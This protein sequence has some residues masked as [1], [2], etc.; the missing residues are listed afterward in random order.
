M[1]GWDNVVEEIFPLPVVVTTFRVGERF[2]AQWDKRSQGPYHYLH[3]YRS[4]QYGR[5][6]THRVGWDN[7]A[8]D[9]ELPMVFK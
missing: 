4:L 8:A 5:G 6:F 3:S 7:R 9:L 2:I 1:K